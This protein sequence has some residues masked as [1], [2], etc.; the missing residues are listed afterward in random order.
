MTTVRSFGTIRKLPSGRYQARYW[1]LGKQVTAGTTFATKTDAR[2]FLAGI[3]TDLKRGTFVD[4]VAGKVTFGEYAGSWLDQRPAQPR[5]RETY[6]SQ[7]NRLLPTFANHD[8]SSITPAEVRTWHGR[9]S[10][11]GLS[12][13]TVARCY[14]CS[15]RS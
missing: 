14:R 3:D 8:P 4:P 9:L 1:Y 2:A 6:E 10:K 12:W 7:L 5:T 13:N 11:S 15:A